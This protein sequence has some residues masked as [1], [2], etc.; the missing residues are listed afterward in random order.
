LPDEEWGESKKEAKEERATADRNDRTVENLAEKPL[1]K[2]LRRAISI[3]FRPIP[4]SVEQDE[5][6][7]L[8]RGCTQC[9]HH[10]E[11]S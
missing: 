3:I 2:H 8:D 1:L 7:A 4:R 9:K 10:R 11:Q 6:R 5:N